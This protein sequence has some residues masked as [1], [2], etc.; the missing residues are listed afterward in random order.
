ME[1]EAFSSLSNK[2]CPLVQQEDLASFGMKTCPLFEKQTI[3]RAQPEDISSCSTRRHVFLFSKEGMPSCWTR[4][5]LFLFNK[6]TCLHVAQ[7]E[8]TL[9]LHSLAV[10]P[11]TPVMQGDFV[12][13]DCCGLPPPPQIQDFLRRS[14]KQRPLAHPWGQWGANRVNLKENI[15]SPEIELFSIFCVICH[16][17]GS[18]RVQNTPTGMGTFCRRAWEMN[19]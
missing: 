18:R 6:N 17:G 13:L 10:S 11:R 8:M 5:H 4:E 12:C 15:E 3:L 2:T 9:R 16:L 7:E 14:I 19:S 1:Q